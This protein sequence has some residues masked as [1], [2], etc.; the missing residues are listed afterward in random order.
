[1]GTESQR[2]YELL[3]T[4]AS[5]VGEHHVHTAYKMFKKSPRGEVGRGRRQ[6]IPKIWIEKAWVRQRGKCNI[7]KREMLL[8]EAAGDHIVP[9]S[10]DGEHKQSNVA[11]VHD[12][13]FGG[14]CNQKKGVRGLIAESKRTGNLLTET[15]PNDES[16]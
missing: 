10:K 6:A 16:A 13:R 12:V 11:A 9:W 1:M 15:L 5:S 8:S 14:T 2:I 3:V 7:C 4:E